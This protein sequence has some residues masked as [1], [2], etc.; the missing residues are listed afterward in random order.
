V[1]NKVEFRKKQRIMPSRTVSGIAFVFLGLAIVAMLVLQ[2]SANSQTASSF[3][4]LRTEN[5]RPPSQ[6]EV[7]TVIVD[8]ANKASPAVVSINVV[9]TKLVR[10]SS[11]GYNDFLDFFFGDMLPPGHLYKYRENIPN[12]GSGVIVTPDGYIVTNEHVVHGAEEI[13]VVTPDGLTLPGKLMGVHEASDIAIIKVDAKADLPYVRMGDSDGLMVGEWAIA[14][15]NPFGNLIED[16]HP[17]VTLGVISAKARS[18]KPATDGKVYVDMLQTDAAINPGN[19]GGP[20]VNYKGEAVGINTFIFTRSGGSLGI[21]FAIPINRVKKILNEV[22]KYGKVRNVWLGFTVTTV[23]EQTAKAL[24]LPAGGALVRSVE[25]RSPADKAG[26]QPGDIISHVNKRAIH[27]AD[28]VLTAFGS[29]LVGESF[30]ITALRK[31]Q[32]LHLALSAE[33]A[34]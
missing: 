23:D 13:T 32:E 10:T 19:S 33:E 25:L 12:I 26:L 30:S 27:E 14:I 17:S 20:L 1:S 24:G 2:H 5:R 3:I 22:E 9:A 34:R 16:A 8:A 6:D 28:D 18:F 11:A 15:G 4:P 21:G 7:R 31:K 29:A